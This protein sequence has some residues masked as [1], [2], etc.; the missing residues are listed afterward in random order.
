[1]EARTWASKK[2]CVRSWDEEYDVELVDAAVTWRKKTLKR[3]KTGREKV[4]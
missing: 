4:A 3:Q 2:I 1:M